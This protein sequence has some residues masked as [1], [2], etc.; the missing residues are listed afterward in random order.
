M[1][2]GCVCV[3][4]CGGGGGGRGWENGQ[5][6]KLTSCSTETHTGESSEC[7]QVCYLTCGEV[8]HTSTEVT[9]QPTTCSNNKLKITFSCS[10]RSLTTPSTCSTFTLP[11]SAIVNPHV[12]A[13][14]GVGGVGGGIRVVLWPLNQKDSKPQGLLWVLKKCLW[15]QQQL[16]LRPVPVVFINEAAVVL[17]TVGSDTISHNHFRISAWRIQKNPRGFRCFSIP[18]TSRYSWSLSLRHAPPS[19]VKTARVTPEHPVEIF[20][21]KDLFCVCDE[22]LTI[23]LFFLSI[24]PS[25]QDIQI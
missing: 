24:L 20:K 13:R 8:T 23:F 10:W 21:I 9:S 2:G 12:H 14:G 15:M 11:L 7:T 22:A 4:V 5:H 3:C 16:F 1:W 18:K 25:A 19:H 6:N 17:L